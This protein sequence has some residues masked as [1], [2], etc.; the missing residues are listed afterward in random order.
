MIVAI[1]FSERSRYIKQTWARQ[2]SKL[3]DRAQKAP[4]NSKTS[5]VPDEAFVACAFKHGKLFL[6]VRL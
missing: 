2:T 3:S 4:S 6:N 1:C 5:Y